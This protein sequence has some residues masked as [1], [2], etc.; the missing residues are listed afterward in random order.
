MRT[1]VGRDE[2]DHLNKRASLRVGSGTPVN[3]LAG[4]TWK[5]IQEGFAV[6]LVA[7]GAAAVNQAA[8]SLALSRGMAAQG[9]VDLLVAPAFENREIDG[10]TRSVLRM[11]VV[12]RRVGT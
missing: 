9:G 2:V 8:K 4:A 5:F 7:I 1:D 11:F 3:K 12:T 10:V 6:D